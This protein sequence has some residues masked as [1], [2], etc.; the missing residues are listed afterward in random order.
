MTLEKE[1]ESF[2]GKVIFQVRLKK[3]LDPFDNQRNTLI[4]LNDITSIIEAEKR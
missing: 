2:K 1:V 4:L 3:I